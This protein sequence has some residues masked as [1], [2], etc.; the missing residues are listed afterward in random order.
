MNT[1]VE[2]LL[3]KYGTTYAEQ[4]QIALEDEP[5][6]LFQLL[7]LCMMQAKPIAAD[8]AVQALLGL[9]KEGL[10]TV[11]KVRDASR[12]Q[13]I[14]VFKRAG[15]SRYDEST[16]TYLQKAAAYIINEFDGDLRQLRNT[17]NVAKALEK[18][19]G[20]GPACS[21]MFIREVQAVWPELSPHFDTKALVGAEK[22]G[23]P[24]DPEELAQLVS[25]EQVP[26][27]AAALVRVALDKKSN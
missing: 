1:C 10:T 26:R 11:E 14:S 9:S 5:A 8:T 13:F 6:P 22:W 18:I 2:E 27:F 23:L 15:Y 3:E 4:A 7:M 20:I 19:G 12:R 25:I 24:V 17:G 21:S 16:T